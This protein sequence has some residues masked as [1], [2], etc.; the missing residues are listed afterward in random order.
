MIEHAT[1]NHFNS[2]KAHNKNRTFMRISFRRLKIRFCLSMWLLMMTCSHPITIWALKRF[3][4][5]FTNQITKFVIPM[6]RS[7]N[8][9]VLKFNS[10]IWKNNTRCRSG[11]KLS[12]KHAKKAQT[13]PKMKKR[14][15][16]QD[17]DQNTIRISSARL[18]LGQKGRIRIIDPTL[19]TS[20]DN[21]LLTRSSIDR[22]WSHLTIHPD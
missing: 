11:F 3:K 22:R 4:W 9:S 5:C 8:N 16:R 19:I 12:Q 1:P 2:K 17:V 13:V 10:L 20:R 7:S 21:N 14:K 6:T 18:K 15:V